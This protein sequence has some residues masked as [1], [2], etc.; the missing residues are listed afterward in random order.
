VTALTRLFGTSGVRGLAN[1]TITP[2]LALKVG[3]ALSTY[4]KAKTILIA[5]DTRTTSPMLQYALVAG[6]TAC[7]ATAL[8]QGIIP[9]PA[10]AYLTKHTK[11]DAGVMITASH[12]PPAYNG[13]KLYN[14]DTSAYNH[15]QQSHIENIIAQREYALANWRKTGRITLIDETPEYIGMVTRAITLKKPWKIVVD[16]GNGA[17]SQLAP[18]IF[19]ELNC[20]A[21]VINAQPD[22]SFPGRGAEP[23]E[24]TLKPLCKLVRKLNADL[25]IAYDGDGDRMITVDDRGRITPPDQTFAA[26]AAHLIKRRDRNKTI[27]TH[28]EASMCIE[29][30]IEAEGGKVVRTSVGDVHITEALGRHDAIFG[31]EPCG[32]WIH[33]N[34]HLCPDGIL[35]SL[36]L[37]Q[38]VEEAN[39]DLAEFVAQA[40]TYPLMRQS[41]DCRNDVKGAV[42]KEA[43]QTLPAIFPTREQTSVDGLRLSLAQGWL[44]VRPSGTEPL[45]RVTAEAETQE[46]VR[47]IMKKATRAIERLVKETKK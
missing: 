47:E 6:V 19:R 15:A 4:T 24:E 3:Q 25:G 8:L 7:G 33:P 40:P 32:A 39:Q 1:I 21:T 22:G 36:L 42:M 18:K 12:N 20:S 46:A 26:Y 27:V 44:L 41:V 29:K 17:T 13:M 16:T 43:Y 38:T 2:Q 30:M 28:V 37:L 45:I 9:T 5:H 34:Y 23:N 35:A 10:L 31:G 14:A 11:S